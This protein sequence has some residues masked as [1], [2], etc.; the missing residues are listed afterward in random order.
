MLARLAARFP[1]EPCLFEPK[2]DGYR[3]LMFRDGDELFMQSRDKKGLNRYFPELE[4]RLLDTLPDRSVT[5]GEIIVLGDGGRLDFEAL[6]QRIHP[7]ASRIELLATKTPARFVAFDLLALGD[8]SL[9]T[10][11]Q[12]ERRSELEQAIGE[13]TDSCWVTPVTRSVQTAR[14]WFTELEA[15]G[16][17][18]IIAKP[19]TLPYQP[20]KRAMLK[21]KHQ[22]TAD[23]VVAGFRW[24][25][26]AP[27]KRIGSLL[28]GLHDD[29]GELHHVGVTA[30]F[31]MQ[32]REQLARELAPLR[33]NALSN[34]PW[35]SWRQDEAEGTRM[36][37][38]KSR[39][40]G[41]KDLGWEP[42]RPERVCEVRYD[43]M[44]GDRFRHATTFVRW[45]P[46]K[47]A[48]D[49]RYDQLRQPD[50]RP[51]ADV[52]HEATA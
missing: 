9:M 39:W 33:D 19:I 22:R 10:I 43:F 2:W 42:L 35:A 46:D 3:A 28:L 49:C 17:D 38:G 6:G 47:P 8:R 29:A 7:A 37:G 1:E 31:R 52:L 40:T 21:L 16:L 24:H 26:S 13:V 18:G 25:K 14:R 30:S 23:C 27:G 51:L 32:V 41:N 45:R 15:G 50:P 34:H 5:D 12:H 4:A 11:P 48:A 44:Q 20:K 36:P